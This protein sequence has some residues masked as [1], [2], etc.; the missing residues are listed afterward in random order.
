[1]KS[2]RARDF[3]VLG[4]LSNPSNSIPMKS[5]GFFFFA[6]HKDKSEI[7]LSTHTPLDL[8]DL[9]G[10]HTKS[11]S[12]IHVDHDKEERLRCLNMN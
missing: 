5:Y 7:D 9:G 3:S 8:H 12:L 4:K 10:A 1:M 2:T 6:P 11:L